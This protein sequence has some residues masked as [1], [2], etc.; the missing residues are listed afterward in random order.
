MRKFVNM[1]SFSG[2]AEGAQ[3]AIDL[4]VGLTYESLTLV[5][6][7]TTFTPAHMTA[8][9]LRLN[10]KSIWDVTGPQLVD[11]NKFYGMTDNTN[12][13]TLWFIRPY[14]ANLL[15][16]RLTAL[17]TKDVQ[18]LSLHIDI[19]GSTAPT[20]AATAMQS[21]A[22]PLGLITKIKS[23]PKTLGAGVNEIDTLPRS[24]A[25]VAAFHLFLDDVVD[26]EIEANGVKI[27]KAAKTL[28]SEM[29]SQSGRTPDADVTHI[30]FLLDGDI[31]HAL[32]T[33]NLQD[34][35][36]RPNS[37]A[38]GALKTVVEYLDGLDGI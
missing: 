11:I 18:T 34:W 29:Q 16:Q 27:Y 30:D 31:R 12:F 24:G 9:E 32:A 38:G 37:T 3:C 7:G 8:I 22:Q 20:L 21:E 5:L 35:R 15:D 13:L 36:L 1:P 4:P 25:R 23:F 28:G 2:V 14:L 17:G 33:V 26:V 10:G 6:G 19:S